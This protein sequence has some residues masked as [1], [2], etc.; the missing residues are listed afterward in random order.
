[1]RPLD[2]DSSRG[3]G[4]TTMSDAL[5]PVDLLSRWVHVGTAIV[6]VGGSVFMRYVLLPSAEQIPDD[7]HAALRGH[8][9]GRWRKFVMIGIALF[10]LS[11]F[12]NYFR[13]MPAH[14]GDGLYHGLVGGKI[15]LS[16]AVFFLASALVGRSPAFEPLRQA[17][18]KWLAVLILLS[19]AVVALG[20]AAKVAAK[21]GR[22]ADH[23]AAAASSRESD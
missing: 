8:V 2:A 16:F 19:A 15:L 18:K 10:L 7:A 9:L 21:P 3:N 17:R 12:Y 6:L 5:L 4:A 14:R 11:G 23:T 20:G 1:M 13:A 22:S